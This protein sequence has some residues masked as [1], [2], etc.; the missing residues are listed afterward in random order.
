MTRYLFGPGSHLSSA[1][2]VELLGWA[3]HAQRHAPTPPPPRHERDQLEAAEAHVM[4]DMGRLLERGWRP[5]A[6]AACEKGR[7]L[8]ASALLACKRCEHLGRTS[9]PQPAY[10]RQ[11]CRSLDCQPCVNIDHQPC[12]GEH[13]CDRAEGLQASSHRW[14]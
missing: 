8:L 7:M 13:A 6:T 5:A 3:A 10:A 12:V 14:W 2:R 1:Q 9:A 11:A 4:R